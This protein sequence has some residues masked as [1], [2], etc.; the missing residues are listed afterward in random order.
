[1]VTVT[2]A[3]GIWEV[4]GKNRRIKVLITPSQAWIDKRNATV[5][6][7]PTDPVKKLRDELVT[8]G[9]L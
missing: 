8:K 7:E 9:V 1:M 3:D 4:R 5:T 6:P 2:D